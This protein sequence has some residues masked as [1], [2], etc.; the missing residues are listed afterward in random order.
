MVWWPYIPWRSDDE[1]AKYVAAEVK[2]GRIPPGIAQGCEAALRAEA[3]GHAIVMSDPK[4]KKR[5]PRKPSWE[6][7]R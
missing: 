4:I 6:M 1:I 7:V 5:P 3:D 2:A